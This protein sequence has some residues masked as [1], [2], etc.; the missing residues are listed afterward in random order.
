M[1]TNSAVP[2]IIRLL[3]KPDGVYRAFIELA[4]LVEEIEERVNGHNSTI[5]LHTYQIAAID[6]RL[7]TAETDIVNLDAAYKAADNQIITDYQ[8][9]DTTLQAQIDFYTDAVAQ[10]TSEIA[11]LNVAVGMP[12]AGG[13]SIEARLDSIEADIGTYSDPDTIA[14]RLSDIETD[15]GHPYAGVNIGSRLDT[16]ETTVTNQDAGDRLDTLEGWVGS[17]MDSDTITTRLD[18][19]ETST[20]HPYTDPDSLDT[21]VTALEGA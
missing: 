17:Y 14:T 10:H 3:K 16:V 13:T 7:T 19:I 12:Y 18:D 5:S 20:G 11:A 4:R 15:I 9:A 2:K 8:Q 6:A 1:G 21:R